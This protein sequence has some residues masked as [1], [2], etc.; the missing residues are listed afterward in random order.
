M[1]AGL[2]LRAATAVFIAMSFRVPAAWGQWTV[3]VELGADR[4][5]GGSVENG[6]ER[7]SFHPYRPTTFG[8]SLERRSGRGGVAIRLLYTQAS[9]ALEGNDAVVAAKGVFKVYSASPE[10]SYRIASVGSSNQALLRV[11]PLF[12]VWSII[13]QKS[14]TRVGVQG[15]ASLGIPLGGSFAA[16]LSAGAA[17]IPSPFE[18]GEL[19][20]GYDLRALWRRRFAV[21][22]QY[23]L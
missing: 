22:L 7:R 11:G 21:G 15:A 18:D 4:F 17:L 20:P 19:L 23:G 2:V 10:V 14:R 8:G 12:E 1:G 5:W 6:P 9:L 3:G 13:D 16:L